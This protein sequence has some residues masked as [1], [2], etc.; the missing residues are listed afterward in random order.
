LWTPNVW[1]I[2]IGLAILGVAFAYAA[3][4]VW[5]AADFDR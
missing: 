2:L 3:Y 4:R 1:P 5:L